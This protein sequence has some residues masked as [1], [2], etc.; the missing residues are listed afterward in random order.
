MHYAMASH[1]PPS[2]SQS[3]DLDSLALA[4]SLAVLPIP[5]SL[6]PPPDPVLL[7]LLLQGTAHFALAVLQ[8]WTLILRM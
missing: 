1:F 7:Q 6:L 5:P 8:A 4:A 3:P 2:E